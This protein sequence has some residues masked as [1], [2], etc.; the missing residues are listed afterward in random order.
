MNLGLSKFVNSKKRHPSWGTKN[1]G[2]KNFKQVKWFLKC[3]YEALKFEASKLTEKKLRLITNANKRPKP[4]LELACPSRINFCTCYCGVLYGKY[5][6]N[7]Y[8]IIRIMVFPL[9]DNFVFGDNFFFW[10]IIFFSPK[11]TKKITQPIKKNY[12]PTNE[13]THPTETPL[14]LWYDVFMPPTPPILGKNRKKI[15]LLYY[16]WEGNFT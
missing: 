1:R 16:R 4:D 7:A 10:L 3:H 14:Y 6:H 15:L 9:D 11:A 8:F 12:S 2:S 5:V 13:V